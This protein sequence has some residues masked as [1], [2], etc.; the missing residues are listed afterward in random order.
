M[1]CGKTFVWAAML[2]MVGAAVTLPAQ[3]PPSPAKPPQLAVRP[4]S[5]AEKKAFLDWVPAHYQSPEDMVVGLFRDR[6]IVFLANGH[7]KQEGEFAQ[8]LMK[9]LHQAGIYNFSYEFVLHANQAKMDTLLAGDAFD[10][11]LAR[12]LVYNRYEDGYLE[13]VDLLKAAWQVN[14]QR[15]KG[16]RPFRIVGINE[17]DG[18]DLAPKGT[19]LPEL[20]RIRNKYLN[21][22]RR[23]VVN[24]TWAGFLSRDFVATKEKA[25]VYVGSA[26]ATTRFRLDRRPLT[27]HFT[28][29]GNLLFNYIGEKAGTVCLDPGGKP[30][31]LDALMAAVPAQY[32]RIGLAPKKGTPPGDLPIAVRGFVDGRA[33]DFTLADY[34][35]GYV[36]G[37]KTGEDKPLTP[38]TRK[39][40]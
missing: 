35:D 9:R 27:A 2:V 20:N 23:D 16:S 28:S 14:R 26:H 17:A 30:K 22:H 37:Y 39:K 38:Y 10:V 29:V 6:D 18:T 15:P 25:L 32:R 4:L 13:D 36:Y 8:G 7:G 34:C 19:P 11:E 1:M 31:E 5:D 3:A 12:E 33:S 40:F 21:G 24:F